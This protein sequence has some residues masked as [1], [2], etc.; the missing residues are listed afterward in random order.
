MVNDGEKI[1]LGT[2]E[3]QFIVLKFIGKED[4]VYCVEQIS[5]L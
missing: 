2:S 1:F 4:A 5:I 3:G